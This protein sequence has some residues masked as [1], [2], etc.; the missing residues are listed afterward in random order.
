MEV[1]RSE[2]I[3][4]AFL[5]QFESCPDPVGGQGTLAAVAT[6]RRITVA[7][8]TDQSAVVGAE[9]RVPFLKRR[10]NSLTRGLTCL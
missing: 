10:G 5:L 3:R 2:N 6:P 4:P 8:A 7:L 1:R 9:W